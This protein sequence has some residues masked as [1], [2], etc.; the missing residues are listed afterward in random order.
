MIQMIYDYNPNWADDYRYR[1]ILAIW[2]YTSH[3]RELII[4][5]HDLKDLFVRS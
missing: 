5:Q 3:D 1:I 2:D 4:I